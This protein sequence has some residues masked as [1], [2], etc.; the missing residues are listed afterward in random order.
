MAKTTK[1]KQEPEV[2]E[3]EFTITVKI[4]NGIYE[5]KSATALEA[6]QTVPIPELIS[7][8]TLTI[9]H[10]DKTKEMLFSGQALKRIF[11]PYHQELLVNDLILGL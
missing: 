4:E 11:N 1:S 3:P 10:G 6:L 7:T 8:G 5:G 2:Q 9:S